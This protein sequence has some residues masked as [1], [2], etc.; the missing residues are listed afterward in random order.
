[1][2]SRENLIQGLYSK[3]TPEQF[4]HFL[5]VLLDAMQFS[6]VRITGRS[7]DRGIDL[8]ATWNES[9]IPGLEID[10][11]FKIQAKRHSPTSTLSPR[12][13]REL[14]GSLRTGDWGLL[15]TTAKVTDATLQERL[16]DTSRIIS[17]ID[18]K[19]L[20]EICK[21]YEI[22]VRKEYEVDLSKITFEEKPLPPQL[23]EP[24]ATTM[25]EMLWSSLGENFVRVGN[26][27]IFRS[28]TRTVI[29]RTSQRYDRADVNY[30]YGTRHKDLERVKEYRVSHFAF[31][32]P[33]VGVLL[34]P[35]DKMLEEI[36]QNN[37][38]LSLNSDGSIS[39][40][41]VQ[42]YEKGPEVYW[43]LKGRDKIVTHWL[44]RFSPKETK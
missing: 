34:I 26:S 11:P 38:Q 23:S 18:G 22:G 37:L 8:E 30:W 33:N 7:G 9:S 29:A 44:L 21:K 15:I 32:F 17:I 12:Y 10:L 42:F 14:R 5:S 2:P 20:I 41:H 16:S 36:K 39:R 3:L 40:Y 31:I 24:G 28:S 4:E 25:Q 6:D 19:K 27:P 43:N 1:M 35:T 13:V